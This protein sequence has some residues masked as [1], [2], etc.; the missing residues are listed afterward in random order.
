[1]N[2][3]AWLRR[4]SFAIFPGVCLLCGC[5]SRRA[6]DL[7]VPCAAGLPLLTTAC[8]RCAL[9][10]PVPGIC[11]ACLQHPP[12]FAA[13]LVACHHLQPVAG[14]IHRLKYGGD[15]AQAAPLA[16][17]LAQRL[18]GRPTQLP[19]ALVP[20]PL[21]WR[22]Q[23]RRGFN[24]ALELALPL[25]RLLDIPVASRLVQRQRATT[26]QVGLSRA[27]RRRNL[28]GAFRV[29]TSA[30]PCHLALIDDVITTGSTLEALADCLLDAGVGRVE[31]W[32]V[33]RAGLAN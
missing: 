11:G 22:R 20:V 2:Y 9:P 18:E 3:S 30:L 4:L 12:P 33:A 14:M 5:P 21:H 29:R 8:E 17:L 15:L 13:A 1:M 31:V 6:L 27:E 28:R 10:L 24:Q 32:A 23:A 16:T 25:G 26:P 19:D 7:C